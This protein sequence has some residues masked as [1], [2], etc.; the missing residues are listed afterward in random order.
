MSLIKNHLHKIMSDFHE[1]SLRRYEE[2]QDQLYRE[3]LEREQN[4]EYYW[5]IVTEKDWEDFAYSKEEKE[6]MVAEAKRHG[7]KFS[8]TKH[9]KGVSYQ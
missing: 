7:L 4:P 8:C 1:T 6:Q 5:H 9:I 2:E 3:E